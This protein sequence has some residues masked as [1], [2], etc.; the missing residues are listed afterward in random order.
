LQIDQRV[1]EGNFVSFVLHANQ[2]SELSD[3]DIEDVFVWDV[4]AP[5]WVAGSHCGFHLLACI[6]PGRGKIIALCERLG[7]LD[8]FFLVSA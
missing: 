3:L 2:F 1:V 7:N 5:I 8:L 6:W 4:S